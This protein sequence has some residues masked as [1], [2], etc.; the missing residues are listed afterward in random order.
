MSSACLCCRGLTQS[1]HQQFPFGTAESL[2]LHKQYDFTWPSVELNA[3]SADRSVSAG[4]LSVPDKVII[5]CPILILHAVLAGSLKNKIASMLLA[6][7][8]SPKN[9]HWRNIGSVKREMSK[10]SYCT[11]TECCTGGL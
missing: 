6:M 5:V 8:W 3:S 4:F 1:S 10:Q 2:F 11:M 9:P 7:L